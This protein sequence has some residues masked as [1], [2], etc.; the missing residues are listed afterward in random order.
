MT[1]TIHLQTK[2]LYNTF[3]YNNIQNTMAKKQ[4]LIP[5]LENAMARALVAKSERLAI[6]SINVHNTVRFED[7]SHDDKLILC[8]ALRIIEKQKS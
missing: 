6:W 3:A 8:E 2:E 7:I 4:L 5:V 1:H